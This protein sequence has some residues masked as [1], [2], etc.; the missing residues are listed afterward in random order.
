M[1]L[2][3]YFRNDKTVI[4]PLP[5]LSFSL[6]HTLAQT[7]ISGAAVFVYF[8]VNGTAAEIEQPFGRWQVSA[9]VATV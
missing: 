2:Q 3:L 4:P 9:V 1:Q 7:L 6:S 5:F 8:S